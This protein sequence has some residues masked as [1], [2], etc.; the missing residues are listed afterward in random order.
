MYRSI[1]G[2]KLVSRT[3]AAR[4]VVL[5]VSLFAVAALPY[6]NAGAWQQQKQV[7]GKKSDA[8]GNAR[9]NTRQSEKPAATAAA[10]KKENGEAQTLA[11][12]PQ[13]QPIN[14]DEDQR[15]ADRRRLLDTIRA[16]AEGGRY[17]LTARRGQQVLHLGRH[18]F[19]DIL[20]LLR[21][22]G[23]SRPK[24]HI[25][26]KPTLTTPIPESLSRL[27]V[28]PSGSFRSSTPSS[29]LIAG[30]NRDFDGWRKLSSDADCL[31]RDQ[32]R[33]AQCG[34]LHQPD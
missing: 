14:S 20:F 28:C 33:H 7:G 4:R 2:R 18:R 27:I 31:W 13:N 6:V 29:P 34:R 8:V 32:T 12:C 17:T 3:R 30:R 9:I 19:R 11:V 22:M 1:P 5:I 23:R 26:R 21:R 24:R 25:D 15:L 16:T 10:V